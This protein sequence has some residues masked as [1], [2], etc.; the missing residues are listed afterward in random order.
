[1]FR[2]SVCAAGQLHDIA[3]SV[4]CMQGDHDAFG[5]GDADR[6]V[7]NCLS[8]PFRLSKLFFGI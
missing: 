2:A 7:I 3:C 8:M 6:E 1:M 4:S 5:G